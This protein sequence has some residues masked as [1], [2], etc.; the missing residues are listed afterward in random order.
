MCLNKP[1]QIRERAAESDMIVAKKIISP[2]DN[3][4]HEECR[5]D[6]PMPAA[7]PGMSHLVCLYDRTRYCAQAQARR[8]RLRHSIGDR[9]EAHRFIRCDRQNVWLSACQKYLEAL[10][11]LVGQQVLNQ[12][13]GRPRI[14]GF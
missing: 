4:A 11:L 5:R 10:R 13:L 3:L 7:C 12:F 2:R 1:A 14:P 9:V 8:K 6:K